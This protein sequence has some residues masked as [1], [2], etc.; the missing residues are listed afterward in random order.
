MIVRTDTGLNCRSL[1]NLTKLE[2]TSFRRA[3]KPPRVF[4]LMRVSMGIGRPDSQFVLHRTVNVT[5]SSC[6]AGA[7]Q[8]HLSP[9]IA[10][11]R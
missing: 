6:C 7:M 2:L 8:G 1:G 9:H 5:K 4:G 10:V 11:L 3:F